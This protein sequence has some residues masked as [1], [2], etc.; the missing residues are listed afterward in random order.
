MKTFL[1]FPNVVQ[2]FNA[3]L[4]SMMNPYIIHPKALKVNG[5]SPRKVNSIKLPITELLVQTSLITLLTKSLASPKPSIMAE[6]S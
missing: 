6:I 1:L 3:L 5:F 2:T 4:E